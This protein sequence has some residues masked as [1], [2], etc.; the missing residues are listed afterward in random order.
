MASDAALIKAESGVLSCTEIL[1]PK[2]LRL[3]EIFEITFLYFEKKKKS[4]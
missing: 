3:A 2:K 4:S 1:T